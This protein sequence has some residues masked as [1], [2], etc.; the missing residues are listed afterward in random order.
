MYTPRRNVPCWQR[1]CRVGT[2]QTNFIVDTVSLESVKISNLQRNAVRSS[3]DDIVHAGTVMAD[4]AQQWSIS[5]R[6]LVVADDD[7]VKKPCEFL[8]SRI[9]R[10]FESR[11][12]IKNGRFERKGCI[13]YGFS[14]CGGR[15]L[16]IVRPWLPPPVFSWPLSSVSALSS[17]RRSIS[18]TNFTHSVRFDTHDSIRKCHEGKSNVS[19][20]KS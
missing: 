15:L 13:Y 6:I 4:T 20:E 16:V 3:G 19:P 5:S 17:S 10:I 1:G 2:V 11:D 18:L 14:H 8:V 12:A 9:S 7:R